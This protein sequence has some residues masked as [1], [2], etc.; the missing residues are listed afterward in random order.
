MLDLAGQRSNA[1]VAVPVARM[2]RLVGFSTR[3]YQ[4]MVVAPI[5]R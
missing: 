5:D 4:D 2:A 3:V 1:S